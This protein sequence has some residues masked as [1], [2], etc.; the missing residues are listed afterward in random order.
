[1]G[2]FTTFRMTHFKLKKNAFTLVEV[3]LSMVII[4][5]LVVAVGQ[6]M[7]VGM[8][9]YSLITDRREALQGARLAVNMMENELQ[10]IVNPATDIIAIAANS[11]TFVPAGGGS[12]TYSVSGNQLLRDTDPLAKNITANTAFT[13][14]TTGGATTSNPAQVYRIHIDI[15]VDTGVV[16]SGKV[17]IKDN[18]YLRNRYYSAFTQI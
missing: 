1:M 3:L 10:T 5:A 6:I 9:S 12:V 17:F 13:Y 16:R 15:E 2:S 8:D 18:V 4:S 11:I 7:L 14:Y